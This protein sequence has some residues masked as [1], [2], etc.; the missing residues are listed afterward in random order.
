VERN[1][2]GER[3]KNEGDSNDCALAQYSTVTST[4]ARCRLEAAFIS[5]RLDYCNDVLY[6]VACRP[7]RGVSTIIHAQVTGGHVITL[8]TSTTANLG[9]CRDLRVLGVGGVS[10]VI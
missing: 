2:K 5:S 1:E 6:A 4:D 8:R 7:I 3:G 9:I 10:S